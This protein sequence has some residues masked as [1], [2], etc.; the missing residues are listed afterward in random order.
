MNRRLIGSLFLIVVVGGWFWLRIMAE[1][2]FFENDDYY[3]SRIIRLEEYKRLK[4]H[5]NKPLV[6]IGMDRIQVRAVL[7]EPDKI[8]QQTTPLGTSEVWLYR[9]TIYTQSKIRF[10]KDSRVI[11]FDL[12]D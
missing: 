7:G 4:L 5:A 6:S 8:E 11:D 12:S 10:N 1:N 9:T 2:G 3:R